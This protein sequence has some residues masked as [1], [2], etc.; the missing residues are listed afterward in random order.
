MP[1]LRIGAYRPTSSTGLHIKSTAIEKQILYIFKCYFKRCTLNSK[2][3]KEKRETTEENQTDLLVNLLLQTFICQYV[4]ASLNDHVTTRLWHSG[5]HSLHL[6]TILWTRLLG[7]T[8]HSERES[9][10]T[11]SMELFVVLLYTGLVN[12]ASA[13]IDGQKWTYSGKC[14]LFFFFYK[15][16]HH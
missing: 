2:H 11:L 14:P 13:G 3:E 15:Y 16:S 4:K 1:V 9:L 12:F 10:C 7:H 8:S 6:F 5:C